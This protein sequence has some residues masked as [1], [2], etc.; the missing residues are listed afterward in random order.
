MHIRMLK[1]RELS[2]AAALSD[3]IFREPGQ[4]SMADAFPYIFSNAIRSVSYGAFDGDK[5]VSFFGLVPW[6]V[7]V[8][9]AR[10]QAFSIGSVCTDPAYQGQGHASSI[11]DEVIAFA[12]RSG[13]SLLFVSGSRSLYTRAH[14]YP[15]GRVRRY[16]VSADTASR[17]AAS[18]A[19][20]ASIDV[21]EADPSDLFA[22]HAAAA[23]MPV[24]YEADVNGIGTLL[25]AEAFA[26]VIKAKQRVFVAEA[27][28]GIQAFA[29]VAFRAE[30]ATVLEW[31]GPAGSVAPLL[32]ACASQPETTALE[33]PVQ[34]H[35]TALREALD[36]AGAAATD[37]NNQGTVRILNADR[38]F[39]Q[40]EPWL[41]GKS[42]ERESL[43]PEQLVAAC[44]GRVDASDSESAAHAAPR[45]WEPVPLPYT[46]GLY[47][48]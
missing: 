29:V 14:C 22:L 10:V 30:R 12:D 33:V 28:D 39:L 44:F 23:A 34:A 46:G 41:R 42:L 13:A 20:A 40:L 3:R 37:E 15:F 24:R 36:A 48:I 1:G 32:G 11:L 8:G 31:A 45:A 6:I 38:L 7:R 19:G 27:A 26:S 17:L 47:F 21:R 18:G 25:K 9:E 16:T 35:E 5:L 2:D 43:S 4:S